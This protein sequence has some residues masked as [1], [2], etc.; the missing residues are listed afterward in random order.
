[1][2]GPGYVLLKETELLDSTSG[3]FSFLFKKSAD[4]PCISVI[5]VIIRIVSIFVRITSHVQIV[6]QNGYIGEIIA[7]K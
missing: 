6:D 3:C 5:G 2:P 1:M 4:D 7:L